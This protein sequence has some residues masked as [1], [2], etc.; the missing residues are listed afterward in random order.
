[1][2]ATLVKT[3][4]R[5]KGINQKMLAKELGV[6]ES[7]ISEICKGTKHPS[8]KMSL[9]LAKYFGVPLNSF[10]SDLFEPD[11]EEL[12]KA[13]LTE[14]EKNKVLEQRCAELESKLSQIRQLLDLS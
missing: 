4:C 12:Q 3:L 7:I 5:Q 10:V 14:R 13:L 6:C 1:M 9:K 8:L 2:T 11:I